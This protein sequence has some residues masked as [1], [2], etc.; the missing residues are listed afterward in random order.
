VLGVFMR[1]AGAPATLSPIPSY[2]FPES[3]A[4][5][6]ARVTAYG[7]WR[8]RAIVRVPEL[9]HFDDAAIRRLVDV[10][11]QRGGGWA[12]PDEAQAL[13]AS[14]GIACAV[15]QVA[16]TQ[17]EA[18]D[19]ASRIGYPVAL[20]ALGPSLLHKTERRAVTLN[21]SGEAGLRAAYEDFETRLGG[22]MTSVLVQQMV[23]RGVEMIVG[24]L[25]D[26]VFGPVIACGTGGILVDVLADMAFRLHPLSGS[27]AAEMVGE[28]RG[29]RLLRGYRGSPPADESALRDVLVRVS[30]LLRV[31]PEVQELD[32]NPVIVL[33]QG[34]QVADVRLRIGAMA[35]P[36]RGRRVEY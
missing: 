13:L 7:Q 34:A 25:Q 6:L 2:A 16:N 21:I 22:E 12:R 36:S 3:A 29:A 11:L 27:D 17:S 28:L 23:P 14:A 20:K 1:S 18:V 4:L 5:A 26:P 19:A 8:S 32:L 10:V 31:A 15:S 24:A 35:P 30:E 9:D 33:P